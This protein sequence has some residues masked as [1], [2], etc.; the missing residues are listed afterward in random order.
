MID[1]GKRDST[2]VSG[3]TRGD[4]TIP[5]A[6]TGDT[7]DSGSNNAISSKEEPET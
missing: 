2:I 7:N 1:S 5:I 3:K 6:P 4:D